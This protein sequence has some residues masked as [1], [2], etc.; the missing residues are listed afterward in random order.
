MTTIRDVARR[1]GLSQATASRALSGRG[2]VSPDAL[3]RVR[4]A[5]QALG[6]QVM[7]VG[8]GRWNGVAIL[9]RVGLEPLDAALPGHPEPR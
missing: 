1:A 8:D 2:P 3:E 9:S 4:A 5:A 6:Y 7:H